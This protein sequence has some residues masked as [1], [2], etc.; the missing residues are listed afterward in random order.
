MTEFQTV[1][2]ERQRMCDK[3]I[4]SICPLG[5]QRELTYD[6][7]PNWIIAHPEKAEK[8]IMDW[9][10]NHKTNLQK[11]KEVFGFDLY[12]KFC[13]PSDAVQNCHDKSICCEDE[14]G[15]CDWFEE[16]S[17]EGK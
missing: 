9:A 3:Y 7:C 14:T 1:I 10:N 13:V 11:F 2:K 15:L 5:H 17:R 6:T 8:I 4:C 12:N 16:L